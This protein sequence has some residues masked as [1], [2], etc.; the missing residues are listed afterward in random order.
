VVRDAGSLNG[1]YV[2]GL[3]VDEAVLS[4]GDLVQVGRYRLIFLERTPTSSG[5]PG[6][7]TP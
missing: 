4:S 5:P 3:R 7:A 1:V 2:N 6:P